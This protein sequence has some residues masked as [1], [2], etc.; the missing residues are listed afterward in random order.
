VQ[1]QRESILRLGIWGLQREGLGQEFLGYNDPPFF[2]VMFM[3]YALL[4]FN[5]FMEHGPVIVDYLNKR[6]S[7]V[8]IWL[9][10]KAMENH[11]FW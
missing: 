11:N 8:T 4:C 6:L 3:G 9:F 10:N 7:R 1:L 2:G 5:M